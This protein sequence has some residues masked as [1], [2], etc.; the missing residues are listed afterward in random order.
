MI[1]Y[2]RSGK[3]WVAELPSFP[4]AYCQGR[5]RAEAYRNLLAVIQDLVDTYAA[6]AKPKRAA[7]AA[8]AR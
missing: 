2:E 6:E 4:G 5:T 8:S 1:V 7:H 3:W